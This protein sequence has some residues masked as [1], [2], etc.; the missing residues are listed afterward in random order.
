MTTGTAKA[1]LMQAPWGAD[2]WS[3]CVAMLSKIPKA[4]RVRGLV[5]LNLKRLFFVLLHSITLFHLW[6]CACSRAYQIHVC[7]CA[8]LCTCTSTSVRFRGRPQLSLAPKESI[9]LLL[10]VRLPRFSWNSLIWLDFWP[11]GSRGPP[12]S[13]CRHICLFTWML[14]IKLTFLSLYGKHFTHWAIS[15]ILSSAL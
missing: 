15:P 14:E 8:C 6:A 2:P 13:E 3:G 4:C 7:G 10:G 5:I 12:A 9:I 11:V 1:G